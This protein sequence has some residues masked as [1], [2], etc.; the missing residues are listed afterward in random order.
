MHDAR[1]FLPVSR[2]GIEEL[3]ANISEMKQTLGDDNDANIGMEEEKTQN[4]PVDMGSVSETT[5]QH[6]INAPEPHINANRSDSP[7]EV[8]LHLSQTSSRDSS[9]TP[10]SSESDPPVLEVEERGFP[11]A[12]PSIDPVTGVHVDPAGIESLPID[13]FDYD[14]DEELFTNLWKDGKSLVVHGLLEKMTIDWTPEYFIQHYGEETCWITDCDSQS[15]TEATV[16]NFFAQFGQ[17]NER[18]Q[19]ILKLKDWPPTSDFK[20]TFPKLFEDFQ[21]AVP[22]PNYTRRDGFY[23]I[24]THFPANVVA[25]DMGPKM[26]NAFASREDGHGSTRLHMDMVSTHILLFASKLI[27]GQADAVNIMLYASPPPGQTIGVA[28][29]DIYPSTVTNTIREFLREEFPPETSPIQ[30]V[31]PIHSQYFYLTP[32]LRRKIFDKYGVR[33][34]RIYQKPGDAVFIP[35]GCAHQV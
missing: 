20:V 29:W 34:W 15:T 24:S 18:D 17:Y 19:K 22:V 35:A 21:S 1:M 3:E 26:Y 12:Q 30:Y 31:D 23:N 8:S 4:G 27:L 16:A 33:G 32:K 13:T 28:V 2:L 25:P 11:L 10:L 14:L 7:T 5:G 9:L 6:Q